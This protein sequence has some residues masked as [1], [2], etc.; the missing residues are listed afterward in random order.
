MTD[1]LQRGGGSGAEL[2]SAGWKW[3]LAYGAFLILGGIVALLNP[4]A[5]GLATGIFFGLILILY[6]IFALMAGFSR[7][8]ARAKILEI[9][10]G[11][12]A[13]AAGVII[14]A[15]P[16][17]GAASLAWAIGLWLF[18]SGIFQ[19]VY[20]LRGAHDRLWR[21]ALGVLDI[22]LGGLLLFSNPVIGIA[23]TVALVGF[24][25]IFRGIFLAAVALG[26]RKLSR[27]L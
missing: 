1:G 2:L 19:L 27:D 16:Y 13:I 6:G 17:Q 12:L 5:T 11:I 8:S 7:L 22:L 3:L 4:A 26:L 21:L 23:F 24:S 10:L 20:L 18:A 25:F 9:L 15:N 14:L